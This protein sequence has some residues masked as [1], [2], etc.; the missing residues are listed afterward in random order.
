VDLAP[1]AGPNEILCRMSL[2]IDGLL[3]VAAIEKSTGKSKEIVIQHALT[4]KTPVEVAAARERL[5]QLF[6]R[7]GRIEA[8]F[9]EAS[10]EE[11]RSDAEVAGEPEAGGLE[12]PA[13]PVE[14]SAGPEPSLDGARARE[15]AQALVERS[16]GRLAEMHEEDRE[17]AIDLHERIEAAL[18]SGDAAA[19]DAGVVQL[20]E[21][22][23][24]IEGR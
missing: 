21:L 6:A 14:E 24:F 19:L 18:A 5:R 10:L 23:F 13:S 9:E 22:L 7:S 12:P 1:T 17:E 8:M 15:V 2:D 4:P 3:R 20:K 11:G 16:R